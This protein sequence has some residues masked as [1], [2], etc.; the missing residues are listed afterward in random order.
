[1]AWVAP[2]LFL[3]SA[4]GCKGR[5]AFRMGYLAGLA[6]YLLSLY[7]LLLIPAGWYPVLGW[8]ALA[9]FLA[10]FPATWVW[11][12]WKI[13]PVEI[14]GDSGSAK[15]LQLN[16]C[17]LK[18]IWAQRMLWS[19][20]GAA[21]WVT[22][23]MVLAR[24][25]GGF[26]WNLLGSSQYRMV[27][28]IQIASRTGIYGVSFL[29]VWTSLSFLSA[30]M[31]ILRTPAKRSAW[32]GEI[33]IPSLVVAGLYASAYTQLLMPKPP[34]PHFTATL[35]QPSIPQTVI[36]DEK[37]NDHRF[38]ELIQLSEKALQEKTTLLIWPEAALPRMIRYDAETFGAISNLAVTHKVWIIVGSDDME[39][40][41]SGNPRDN[42]YFNSSFLISPRGNLVERYCKRQLV[43]FGEYIP[44]VKWLPFI[45]YLTPIDGGFTAGEAATPFHLGDTGIQLSTLICFE[46]VFPQLAREYV[47]ENTDFLVNITNDGWFGEGAAQWQQGAAAAFRAVENG[48]PLVRCSN[49]GL[50]CLIDA[51]GRLLQI[52]KDAKG[53]IY[54]PGFLRVEIPLNQPSNH[55]IRTYYNQHGDVFGVSCAVY[56]ALLLFRRFRAQATMDESSES[57]TSLEK[58]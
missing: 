13:F 53:K 40:A 24:I 49:T 52:F 23:E 17:F 28:L 9:A 35:V 20:G 30:G 51:N 18:S 43:I 33:I 4:V 25:F 37:E 36:W 11:L 3:V 22:M 38:R 7:W 57:R 44:L 6:H 29:L 58:T 34:Q 1:M 56:S 15:I 16:D 41:G 48:V 31:V 14:R 2:A 42:N 19:M 32:V 55:R 45:K 46:D 54:G 12:T 26:P 27:P 39:P 21:L 50:T 10:L 5:R 8:L 47:T